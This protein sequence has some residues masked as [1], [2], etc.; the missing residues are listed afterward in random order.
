[1]KEDNR[2]LFRQILH[3]YSDNNG[4]C[5]CLTL[6]YHQQGLPNLLVIDMHIKKML[7][8]V[9]KWDRIIPLKFIDG[10]SKKGLTEMLSTLR[11]NDT[12]ARNFVLSER[13]NFFL[14]T[15]NRFLSNFQKIYLTG[16]WDHF[17]I[18]NVTVKDFNIRGI[19][20]CQPSGKIYSYADIISG[21]VNVYLESCDKKEHK[22]LSLADIRRLFQYHDYRNGFKLFLDAFF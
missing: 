7:L 18:N 13:F 22:L 12:I 15:T 5:D 2:E 8:C 1:M 19:E 9:V 14:D 21:K 20:M 10:F 16:K 4:E 17:T 11:P 6:F 3:I